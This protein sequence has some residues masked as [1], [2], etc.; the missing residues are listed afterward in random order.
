MNVMIQDLV[1][2]ARLEGGQFP[3]ECK[4][5]EL[6]TYLVELL[7]RNATTLP[8]QSIRL[9]IP[10]A[11]PAISADSMRLER[12]FTNL[13]S[14]AVKYSDPG[15]PVVLR[16]RRVGGFV[17][18]SVID[19]GRGIAAEELPHLFERFYRAKGGRKTE[20]VGLGL[21]ITRK[22][23]EAHGGGIWVESEL[24]KGSTFYFTLPVAK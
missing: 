14:N 24:D 3:L 2:A 17:E 18:V 1:D 4:P 11:L 23:V 19:Q 20:G 16:V 5:L 10:E 6:Q 9:D 12:I 21:Y 8:V 13:L 15:S 22:L 7:Q